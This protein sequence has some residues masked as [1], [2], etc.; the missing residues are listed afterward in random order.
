MSH[1]KRWV[2]IAVYSVAPVTFQPIAGSLGGA[3]GYSHRLTT[4][5]GERQLSAFVELPHLPQ[6]RRER[7]ASPV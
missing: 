3:P 6:D 2:V 4:G 7:A 5:S 1:R